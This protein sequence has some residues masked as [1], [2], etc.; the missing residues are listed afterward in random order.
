[1]LDFLSENYIWF[2]VAAIVLLFA[3][4]GF[5]VEGKKKKSKEFKG[6]SV[7]ENVENINNASGLEVNDIPVAETLNNIS[8]EPTVPVESATEPQTIAETNT[9]ETLQGVNVSEQTSPSTNE[10][11]S[12]TIG[13][14]I[15]MKSEPVI[16]TAPES[17]YDEPLMPDNGQE[18]PMNFEINPN[19][20][21]NTERQ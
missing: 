13:E 2:F 6:E 14:P 19:E 18:K 16:P 11:Q 21:N 5:I 17:F 7:N 3:L 8:N 15:E 20:N 12:V 9:M 10:N 1:M 4:I